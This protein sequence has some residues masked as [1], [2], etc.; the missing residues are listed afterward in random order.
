MSGSRGLLLPYVRLPRVRLPAIVLP[1]IAW[2][3]CEL[4]PFALRPDGVPAPGLR[5]TLPRPQRAAAGA[6][7]GMGLG[8]AAW[9]VSPMAAGAFSYEFGG[10]AVGFAVAL[11]GARMASR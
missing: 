1:P 3:P 10:L 5:L 9:G 6:V 7:F 2:R 11:L 8:E 4:R